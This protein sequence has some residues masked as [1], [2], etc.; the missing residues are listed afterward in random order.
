MQSIKRTALP[1]AAWQTRMLGAGAAVLALWS[2]PVHATTSVIDQQQPAATD[3]FAAPVYSFG[4]LFTPT[5]GTVSGGGFFFTGDDQPMTLSINL[6]SGVPGAA[7]DPS[8]APGVLLATQTGSAS[9]GPAGS[10]F[11]LFFDKPVAVTPG[12]AYFL[13]SVGGFGAGS[14]STTAYSTPSVSNGGGAWWAP[15][16][17]LNY[18]RIGGRELTFREYALT[19]A[20][21]EPSAPALL[22]MGLAVLAVTTRRKA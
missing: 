5:Q 22:A 16:G 4:Q 10:Y 6:W 18:Y 14:R 21:P 1:P 7:G 11:D 3:P 9:F 20:V 19:S 13:Q 17:G 12:T 2:C 8:A 15:Y